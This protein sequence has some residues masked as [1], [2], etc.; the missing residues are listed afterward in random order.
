M[1]VMKINNK[2]NM[3]RLERLYELLDVCLADIPD[4]PVLEYYQARNMNY[5]IQIISVIRKTMKEE[6]ERWDQ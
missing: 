6:D 3:M 2:E 5:Y 1:K 4:N